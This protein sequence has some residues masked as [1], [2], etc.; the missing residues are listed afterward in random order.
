MALT[1]AQIQAILSGI[2]P[3][4]MDGFAS[5]PDSVISTMTAEELNQGLECGTLSLEDLN[6]LFLYGFLA[7]QK[8]L[9]VSK[10]Y[11][12]AQVSGKKYDCSWI[13]PRAGNLIVL[14]PQPDGSCLP[15]YGTAAEDDVESLYINVNGD[16]SAAGTKASPL[17]DAWAA[18]G[19]GT[20]GT[21]RRLFFAEGQTHYVD[22]EYVAEY[23]GGEFVVSIYGPQFDALPEVVGDH[24][25]TQAAAKAL[26][27]K[28]KSRPATI[29]DGYQENAALIPTMGAKVIYIGFAEL[30]PA[31]DNG[32]GAP[33]ARNKGT[34]SSFGQGGSVVLRNT[35]V[36]LVGTSY[37]F[38][39]Y[40]LANF[41]LT[42]EEKV[43]VT[44][45]GKLITPD[46]SRTFTLNIS[47]NQAAIVPFLPPLTT[48]TK[49][50]TAINTNLN[51]NLLP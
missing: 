38:D 30:S 12:D 35:D 31:G 5:N 44:G 6:Y 42:V 19:R 32:S 33:R 34:F 2:N 27:T 24:K 16:N 4:E 23:R 47:E 40:A 37:A 49:V 50:V 43:V 28:I 1:Q 10:N 3:A 45:S 25:A 39:A 7:T 9:E 46:V 18:L 21:K 15:Y 48:A 29:R 17:K 51:A 26:G 14:D 41:S 36:H 20:S 22:P 8:S 11:T 13:S